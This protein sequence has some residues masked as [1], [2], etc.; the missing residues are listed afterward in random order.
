MNPTNAALTYIE[1][2]TPRAK[3]PCM[4]DHPEIMAR[5]FIRPTENRHRS[6]WKRVKQT[7]G[8]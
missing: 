1:R 8:F 2:R 4:S 3:V 7:L 5:L 6:W